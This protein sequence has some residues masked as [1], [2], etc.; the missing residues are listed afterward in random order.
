MV[1]TQTISIE[2]DDLWILNI[3]KPR[4]WKVLPLFNRRN[5]KL[6]L[7]KALRQRK[8]EFYYISL[9]YWRSN[10]IRYKIICFHAIVMKY[11]KAKHLDKYFLTFKQSYLSRKPHFSFSFSIDI[12]L[13]Y[14]NK[15]SCG[16]VSCCI[17][18]SKRHGLLLNPWTQYKQAFNASY[19]IPRWCVSRGKWKQIA[20]IF[21]SQYFRPIIAIN[22]L[23]A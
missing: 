1:N 19:Y 5:A 11:V 12:H 4:N 8:L 16:K 2:Y 15:K 6:T 20:N 22:I 23:N 21:S 17:V 9:W 13:R 10:I 3:P 7:D 14:N 18:V